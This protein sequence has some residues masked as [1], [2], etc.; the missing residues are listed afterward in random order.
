[1]AYS[2]ERQHV[3]LMKRFNQTVSTMIVWYEF[4]V[5]FEY[6]KIPKRSTIG[7]LLNKFETSGNVTRN[8]K[9][10][11]GK[12]MAVRTPENI[13]CGEKAGELIYVVTL[14]CFWRTCHSIP[15]YMV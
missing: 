15:K 8:R 7:K 13:H 1:M 9:G 2:V 3:F 10:V 4:C 14:I 5:N 6:T 11:V 12:G